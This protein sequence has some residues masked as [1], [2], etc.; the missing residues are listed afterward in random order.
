MGIYIPEGQNVRIT[1]QI[2][3]SDELFKAE[4]YVLGD[5]V[6][7][8]VRSY[9]S[10]YGRLNRELHSMY[11]LKVKAS[12]VD[13]DGGAT[14][15]TTTDLIVF[16]TDLNDLQPLFDYRVYNVSVKEDTP[17]H[18]SIARVTAFDGDEGINAEIYY[19]LTEKT[20]IF[21][22]HPTS[23]IVS[24]TRHLNY[25]KKKTWKLSLTNGFLFYFKIGR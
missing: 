8:L 17:L 5:F 21:S 15:E 16:I 4:D 25:H 13:K 14:Y 1:Y 19:S 24:L 22:V 3:N 2:E 12:A 20:N 18:T 10:S 11:R 23:G 6:F 7:L 9:S